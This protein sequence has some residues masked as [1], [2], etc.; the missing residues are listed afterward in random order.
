MA[1]ITFIE[2]VMIVWTFYIVLLLVYD[3]DIAGDR[4][5]LTYLVAFGS[6]FWSVYLFVQLIKI[7]KL[8]YAIRYAIPTVVIFWNFVEVLGRWDMFKEIWVHPKEHWL[9]VGLITASL[10]LFVVLYVRE[11]LLTGRQKRMSVHRGAL[12]S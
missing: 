2:L 5:P 8:D 7:Q 11:S 3:K 12:E 1:L 6:L 4:H 10:V 9:E